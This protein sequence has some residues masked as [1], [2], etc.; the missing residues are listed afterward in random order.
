MSA[1]TLLTRG[2]VHEDTRAG[3]HNSGEA[4]ALK[5]QLARV[6]G[7]AKDAWKKSGKN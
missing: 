2:L 3:I 6:A 4:G 7:F 1:E 5:Y